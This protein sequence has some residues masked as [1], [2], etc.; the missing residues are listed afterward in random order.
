MARRPN[1]LLVFADQM[2]AEALG[3]ANPQVQTPCLDRM[4]AQGVTFTNAIANLPLCTPSRASLLT[5]RYPLGCRSV[6]ND[7][8][9]PTDQVT[10]AHV[11]GEAGYRTGYVGKWHLDRWPRSRFTPPGPDRQGFADYWAVHNCTHRYFA[12]RYYLDTPELITPEGYEP[13]VQTE[14]ALGF[15]RRFRDDPWCLVLSWGPPHDPYDQVP[16]RYRAIYDPEK[17]VLRPNCGPEANRRVIADYYAAVTALDENCGRLLVA[18]EELGLAEDTLVVFTSDHG[19]MLYSQGRSQKQAPWEEAIGIPL[20]MRWP[21]V[22]PAGLTSPELFGIA[23]LAP[24][25]LSLLGC[26]VPPVME[27]EDLAALIRGRQPPGRSSVPIMSLVPTD[28]AKRYQDRPWRGVRTPRHTYARWQ[29]RAW[30][31]YDHQA[32]PYQLHNLVDDPAHAEL[33]AELEAEL[34]RWLDR[35]HDPFPDEQGCLALLGLTREWEERQA[36]FHHGGNW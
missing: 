27:G 29:D 8:P 17:L 16:E 24:T 11:L 2:R 20:L 33:Q 6:V 9:L 13:E 34:G 30:V 1:L 21:G 7:L 36:H 31:L 25:L 5:G 15:L 4:G 35:L 3:S 22:L 12:P 32:D 18:L 28:N 26:P 14:L 10:F 19:D 23:D